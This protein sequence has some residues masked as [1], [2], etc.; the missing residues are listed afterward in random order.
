MPYT[1]PLALDPASRSDDEWLEVSGRLSL[2]DG[3]YVLDPET[4]TP[5][6]AP[7][8]PYLY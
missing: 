4:V 1:V 8:D 2:S 7:S 5:V 6:D 3:V